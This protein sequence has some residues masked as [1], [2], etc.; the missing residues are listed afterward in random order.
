[1]IACLLIRE[2]TDFYYFFLNHFF[3]YKFKKKLFFI[4]IFFIFYRVE[5]LPKGT[6][7]DIIRYFKKIL[8]KIGN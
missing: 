6:C 1:M 8:S 5:I 3:F 7:K 2:N 4:I